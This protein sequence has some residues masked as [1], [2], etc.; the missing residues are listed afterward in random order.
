MKRQV[1]KWLSL[2]NHQAALLTIINRFAFHSWNYQEN[3]KKNTR[4]NS[5]VEFLAE[6][7]LVISL[8]ACCRVNDTGRV[9]FNQPSPPRHFQDNEDNKRVTQTRQGADPIYRHHTNIQHVT[10]TYLSTQLHF[11]KLFCYPHPHLV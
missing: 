3:Y 5:Q 9:R 10:S 1:C 7:V 11:S 4:F 8:N 6:E 2:H